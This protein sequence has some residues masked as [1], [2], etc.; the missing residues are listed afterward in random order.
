MAIMYIS[1][2]IPKIPHSYGCSTH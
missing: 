2:L 1:I